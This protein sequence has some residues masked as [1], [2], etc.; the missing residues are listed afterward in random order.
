ME[1]QLSK[2]VAL[3]L[4]LGPK[5]ARL[6]AR[7]PRATDWFE[8]IRELLDLHGFKI[9]SD[10]GLIHEGITKG[11]Q[12]RDLVAHSVWVKAKDGAYVIRRIKGSWTPPGHRGKI[13]RKIKPQ[14]ERFEADECRTFR[15]IIEATSNRLDAL[16]AEIEDALKASPRKPR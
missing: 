10:L 13:N 3:L 2:L 4:G 15:E 16:E 14:G 5:E 12:G 7:E 11:N 8:L 6:A 9:K 1:L